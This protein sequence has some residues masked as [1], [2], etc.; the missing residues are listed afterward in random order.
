GDDDRGLRGGIDDTRKQGG[1][2]IWCHNSSGFEDVPSALSG[3]LDAL[4]VFDGTRLGTYEESYYRYL[5]IGLRMPLS[6]GTDWFLYDFSRVYAR[7]SG[8]VSIKGW[9]EAVKAG[10]CVATNGPLLSLAVN[11]KEIGETVALAQR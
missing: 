5:N 9:L 2:V 11:G 6:T 10:R 7:L 1:T 8:P 3:R 4:N